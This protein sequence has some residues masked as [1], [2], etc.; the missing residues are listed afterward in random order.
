MMSQQT[1]S[2]MVQ[3]LADAHASSQAAVE[4]VARLQQMI[5]GFI[6]TCLIYVA[7]QFRVADHLASGP[8]SVGELAV[9]TETQVEPL[10]RVLRGLAAVGLLR[11]ESNDTFEL[12]DMGVYLRSDLPDEQRTWALLWGHEIF[13]RAWGDLSHAL[14]TGEIPFDHVFR[15]PFFDY[16]AEHQDVGHVFNVAMSARSRREHDAV[17]ATYDFSPYKRI[18]DVGGGAGGLLAAICA[19]YP[20][21]EG[22]VF[23]LASGHAE[24]ERTFR[25]AGLASRCRFVVGN[26]FES[27]PPAGDLVVLSR[28]L[29]DWNDEHAVVILRNCERA[30]ERGGRLLVVDRVMV[31]G[32]NQVDGVMADLQML[33]T[34][35]G[36]ERTEAEFAALFAA[37]G[38]QRQNAIATNSSVW[39]LEVVRP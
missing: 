9:R 20:T 6:S 7:A 29:H 35:G 23:D 12:T 10:R 17:L 5:T 30:I 24:A 15:Q 26:F 2:D 22:I 25:S 4:P 33:A 32:Q 27:T 18:V 36:R 16:L 28:V 34:S 14:K 21:A 38:L 31:P 13:P 1:Q 11:E 39:L 19:R 8:L 37:A 3:P